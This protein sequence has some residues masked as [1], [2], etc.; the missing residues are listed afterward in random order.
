MLV[1][2]ADSKLRYVADRLGWTI[3]AERQRE[4]HADERM[5]DA[6]RRPRPSR[7]RKRGG[8][9]TDTATPSDAADA[10]CQIHAAPEGQAGCNLARERVADTTTPDPVPLSPRPAPLTFGQA[11]AA[12]LGAAV[13][14]RE[15][16]VVERRPALPV[17]PDGRCR[18]GAPLTPTIDKRHAVCMTCNATGHGRNRRVT[19]PVRYLLT[20][21]DASM[22]AAIAAD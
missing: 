14:E 10:P 7:G 6:A 11:V 13:V 15:L 4:R 5:D 20:P 12:S 2:D 18:C 3:Q 21:E 16:T 1:P 22:Y 8:A 17:S 19:W 9:T